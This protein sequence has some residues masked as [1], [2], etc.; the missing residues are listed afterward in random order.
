MTGIVIDDDDDDN[1]V[2]RVG[3]ISKKR[4]FTAN[5]NRQGSPNLMIGVI[6]LLGS[7]RTIATPDQST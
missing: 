5:L 6:A 7:P 1:R 4:F 3:C 2:F